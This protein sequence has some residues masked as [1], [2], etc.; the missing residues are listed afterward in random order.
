MVKKAKTLI[1]VTVILSLLLIASVTFIII[2]QLFIVDIEIRNEGE[3]CNA[4]NLICNTPN[5]HCIKTNL[6]NEGA[7]INVNTFSCS[8][9]ENCFTGYI[10]ID[11]ECML[12]SSI[13]D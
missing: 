7:C 3:S 5:L 1:I 6:P 12:P 2:T 10:C 8:S 9:D 4:K 11:G 13:M